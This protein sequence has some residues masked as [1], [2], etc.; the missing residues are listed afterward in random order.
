M[1]LPNLFANLP[2]LVT[3]LHDRVTVTNWLKISTP[4]SDTYDI[5]SWN[6]QLL[7][8]AVGGNPEHQRSM[9]VSVN[10]EISFAFV[11]QVRVSVSVPLSKSVSVS[12]L[13]MKNFPSLL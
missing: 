4:M 11:A 13:S 8:S 9:V 2:N 10:E 1:K 7:S 6:G 3:N 5:E 12:V